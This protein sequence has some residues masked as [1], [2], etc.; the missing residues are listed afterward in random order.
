M[1]PKLQ[2]KLQISL[3]HQMTRLSVHKQH[4]NGEFYRY[5]FSFISFGRNSQCRSVTIITAVLQLG[6]VI[7]IYDQLATPVGNEAA[8]DRRRRKLLSVYT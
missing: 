8:R 5:H 7:N 2:T 3:V 1:Q 4:I 6:M